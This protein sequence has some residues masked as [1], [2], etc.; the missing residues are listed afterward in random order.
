MSGTAEVLCTDWVRLCAED[1]VPAGEA[2]AFFLGEHRLCAVN[3]GSSYFVV[4]DLCSHGVAY[5]SEGYCDTDECQLECPL[6]GGLF[7]YRDGAACGDPAEKPVRTYP[8]R[9]EDGVVMVRLQ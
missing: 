2:K 3:D 4:D 8:I 1:A 7:D 9:I 5:L 6:H